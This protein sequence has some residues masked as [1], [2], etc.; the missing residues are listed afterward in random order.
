MDL[1]SKEAQ[2]EFSPL[3]EKEVLIVSA[4]ELSNKDIKLQPTDLDHL[5]FSNFSESTAIYDDYMTFKGLPTKSSKFAPLM[6][7][8]P[9]L[10]SQDHYMSTSFLHISS[11]ISKF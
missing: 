1:D 8:V 9:H 2:L 11:L 7:L 3:I 6:L 5:S 10:R 4:L